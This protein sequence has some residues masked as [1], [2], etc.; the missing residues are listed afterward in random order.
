MHLALLSIHVIRFLVSCNDSSRGNFPGNI[1]SEVT[2]W[3][4]DERGAKL[5]S[6]EV[7]PKASK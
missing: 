3:P 4:A 1:Q 5:V 6:I 2:R 7:G